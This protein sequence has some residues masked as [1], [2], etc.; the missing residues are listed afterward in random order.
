MATPNISWDLTY[1]VIL[2]ITTV[3]DLQNVSVCAHVADK[4]SNN[5]ASSWKRRHCDCQLA[6][7]A[8]TAGQLPAAYPRRLS[9]PVK[10]QTNGMACAKFDQ[11]LYQKSRRISSI[12]EIFPQKKYHCVQFTEPSY[13]PRFSLLVPVL[14]MS[15]YMSMLFISKLT[16]KMRRQVN[17]GLIVG[18]V[19]TLSLRRTPTVYLT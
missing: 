3:F 10:K 13:N 14:T 2:R 9:L 18:L 19:T 17:L 1:L 5:G 4:I 8:T 7:I 11:M 6:R 16:I 15:T 12:S